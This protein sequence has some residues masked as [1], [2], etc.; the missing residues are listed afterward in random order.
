[1]EKIWCQECGNM[2]YT[3]FHEDLRNES[4]IVYRGC[5]E[6]CAAIEIAIDYDPT[7]SE[8]NVEDS[9]YCDMCGEVIHKDKFCVDTKICLECKDEEE[10]E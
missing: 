9:M 1:M 6:C 5:P 3:C 4:E 8:S 10:N 2:W 7:Y